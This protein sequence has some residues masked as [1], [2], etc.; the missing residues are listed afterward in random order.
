MSITAPRIWHQD[1]E[2]YLQQQQA[3]H[4]E[5]HHQSTG[6]LREG[7]D[8]FTSTSSDSATKRANSTNREKNT[9][10]KPTH[11]QAHVQPNCR[12]HDMANA[13]ACQERELNGPRDIFVKGYAGDLC[14]T[15]GAPRAEGR[16][17]GVFFVKGYGGDLTM[18]SPVSLS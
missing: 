10:T 12:L 15:L 13:S 4:P 14:S 9:T 2:G 6:S 11:T 16:L 7:T 3:H 5:Q 1:E 17:K 18:L 8:S